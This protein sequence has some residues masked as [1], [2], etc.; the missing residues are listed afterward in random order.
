MSKLRYVLLRDRLN[1]Q[2]L[3]AREVPAILTLSPAS[4]TLNEHAGP[5]GATLVTLTRSDTDLPN[6]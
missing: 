6:P 4:G 5:A 2:Q 1:V 3:E